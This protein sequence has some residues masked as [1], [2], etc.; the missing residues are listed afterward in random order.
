VESRRVVGHRLGDIPPWDAAKQALQCGHGGELRGKGKPTW[1]SMTNIERFNAATEGNSVER[2]YMT[3]RG[4]EALIGRFNAAT[5]GNSVE[6]LHRRGRAV[7]GQ[8]GFSASMRPRRGTPWKAGPRWGCPSR[9]WV[10]LQCGHGG[11]LRGKI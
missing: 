6:S 4:L 1:F 8:R 3:A 10:R 11:E 5:E 7:N 2:A 9:G